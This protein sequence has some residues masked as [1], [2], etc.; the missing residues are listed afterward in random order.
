MGDS[1]DHQDDNARI[2]DVETASRD[3]AVVAS[4]FFDRQRPDG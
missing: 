2:V 4:D 3:Y 1:W